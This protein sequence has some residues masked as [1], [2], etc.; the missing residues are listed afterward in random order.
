MCYPCHVDNETFDK[1]ERKFERFLGGFN[2][3]QLLDDMYFHF[4]QYPFQKESYL[5]CDIC[6]HK[7]S[8]FIE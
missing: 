7:I 6:A 5:F 1:V 2:M 8:E 4:N 3:E